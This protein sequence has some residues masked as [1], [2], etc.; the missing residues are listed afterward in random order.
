M[1]KMMTFFQ[2]SVGD[3]QTNP[4]MPPQYEPELS[5][6]GRKPRAV[7][8]TESDTASLASSEDLSPHMERVSTQDKD[9]KK[10]KKK[11]K[12]IIK[13]F[14]VLTRGMRKKSHSGPTAEVPETVVKPDAPPPTVEELYSALKQERLE[15]AP[16]LL[17]LERALVQDTTGMNEEDLICQQSKVEALY[18]LLWSAVLRVVRRPLENEPELLLQ[19]LNVIL[20][21]EQEDQRVAAE[22]RGPS[23]LATTRPRHWLK[24]WQENV[25][26]SVEERMTRPPSAI[27]DGPRPEGMEASSEAAQSFLYMGK[28][29]KED[30]LAV[31]QRLQ[32]LYPAE[33]NVFCTY[34]T[35]YHNYFSSQLTAMTQFELNDQDTSLLLLW[36]KNL[37]PNDIINHPKLSEELQAAGLGSLLPPKKTR[38]LEVDYISNE[39][40]NVQELMMR[41]LALEVERWSEDEE[42]MN[43]EGYFHSELPIDII[44]IIS[45]AQVKADTRAL[46]EQMKPLLMAKF[47][48]FLKSY[49]QAFADF[50]EKSKPKHYRATIMANINNCLTFRT[51]TDKESKAMEKDLSSYIFH[52]L[53]EIEQSGFNILLQNLFLA[54][55]SLFKRLTQTRWATHE[56]TV[57]EIIKI[58]SDCLPEFKALRKRYQEDIMEAIHLYLVKE[59]I[60]R[61]SKRRLVLRTADL[62]LNLAD[63]ISADAKNIQCFCAQNGSPAAWLE[64]AL[65][66]LAEIIRLQDTSAIKIEVATFASRFPDFSKGHLGAILTIKGNLSN[67]EIKSIKS[68]LDVSTLLTDS[69]RSLFSLIKVG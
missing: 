67:S 63:Q 13:M 62:Q 4:S 24:R 2:T 17:M 6:T 51:Y 30:L 68:I 57:A 9:E 25:K 12:G 19:A 31:A 50:T 21:Q 46:G 16:H 26:D 3:H 36:V 44:Q 32:P 34:A 41:G 28:T 1:M 54:L 56:E 65:P 11:K 55:K 52:P 60:I 38:K 37:Y 58:T 48:S 64:P 22:E 29:M 53:R 33:F 23:V 8:E 18:T 20:E 14:D 40:A 47:S 49:Q 35:C 27:L 7:S 69:S 43:L 59:Y 66:T 39:T 42:P 15:M 45:A 5:P 10:K 61:L